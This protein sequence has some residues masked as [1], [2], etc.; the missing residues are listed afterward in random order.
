MH[1]IHGTWI[2]EDSHAF[3][4]SGAFYLWVETDTPIGTTRHRGDPVHPRHLM[5]TALAAFL[6]EK[7]GLRETLTQ[8]GHKRN[9]TAEAEITGLLPKELLGTGVGHLRQP[10][11]QW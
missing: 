3:I 9:R 8:H 1:I 6:T 11:C 5:S 4:Q 7:L 2:P 10:P